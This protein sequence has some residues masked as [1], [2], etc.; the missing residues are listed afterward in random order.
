MSEAILAN[1]E[2][3]TASRKTLVLATLNAQQ[4][5]EI[6]VTPFIKQGIHFYIFVSD[7][8][9]HTRNIKIHPELSIML[10]EDEQDTANCFA[11]KRLSYQCRASEISKNNSNREILID[12]FEAQHG[13]TV[14]LLRSLP[15]FRLFELQA[16]NGNYV[17]GFG[18][19]YFLSGEQLNEVTLQGK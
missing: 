14:S 5:A 19:A 12:A 13:K 18:Q 7:L 3:L 4:Q 1:I 11:R 17:Q 16:M 15:D 6:S 8:S 2:A 9:N 10:M